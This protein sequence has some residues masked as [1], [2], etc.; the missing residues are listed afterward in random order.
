VRLLRTALA[1]QPEP[2]TAEQLARNFARARTD[3]VAD[4][5]E[6]LVTLG[7]ARTLE[8]GRYTVG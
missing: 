5:L 3:R 2:V 4:L 8:D 6:T 1:A 7:Q